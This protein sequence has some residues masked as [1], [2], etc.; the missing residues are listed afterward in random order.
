MA[1]DRFAQNMS[2]ADA[3]SAPSSRGS[4]S[5]RALGKPPA[6]SNSGY[7]RLGGGRSCRAKQR[8]RV[9][10]SARGLVAAHS[11]RG[12]HTHAARSSFRGHVPKRFVHM[13]KTCW[14]VS[15][16]R[17]MFHSEAQESPGA[18]AGGHTNNDGSGP[19]NDQ[20]RHAKR[21]NTSLIGPC[22]LVLL[23]RPTRSDLLLLEGTQ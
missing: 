7:G 12:R 15:Q 4:R 6:G 3:E 9:Q 22:R 19:T 2:D 10:N 17:A 18:L 16:I 11:K 23:Y 20:Q 13:H 21:S 5:T 1:G 14:R 8:H